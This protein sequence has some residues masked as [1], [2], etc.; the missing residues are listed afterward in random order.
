MFT[1]EELLRGVWG[2]R[3][4]GS[5]RTLDSH[6]SR[7]RKKLGG[8][9][10]GFVVNVWGV[11]Y[12]LIDGG[13]ERMIA[14]AA[15]AGWVAAAVVTAL[16][17]V[18]QRAL[19]TRMEAVARACHELRGPLTAARLGLE[20]GSRAEHVV[21]GTAGGDRVELGRASLALD[22]L[23][24]AG[25]A[26]SAPGELTSGRPARAAVGLGS[27]PGSRS[28]RGRAS[29]CDCSARGGCPRSGATG[30][31]SPRRPAT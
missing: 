5:T 17:L 7:L 19:D 20:L 16:W 28:R 26:R 6:A 22:D 12:R 15:S 25:E 18:V 13:V 23:S 29:S 10:G 30:C 4:L 3:S 11:G 8:A 9:G 24:C 1:R 2:F 31:G 27:R 21:A 14:A